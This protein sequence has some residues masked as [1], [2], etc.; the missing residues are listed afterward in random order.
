MGTLAKLLGIVF[1]LFILYVLT[2]VV[3][4]SVILVIIGACIVGLIVLCN[5]G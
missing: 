2:F 4:M 5:E 1:C 3:P